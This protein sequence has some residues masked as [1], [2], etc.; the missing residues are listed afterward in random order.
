MFFISICACII[1]LLPQFVTEFLHKNYWIFVLLLIQQNIR[2][3][4]AYNC[5]MLLS[6]YWWMSDK[7]EA[8]CNIYLTLNLTTLLFTF[9]F[10]IKHS[11]KKYIQFVEFPHF[12]LFKQIIQWNLFFMSFPLF[13]Y[14]HSQSLY[15]NLTI[16]SFQHYI[17]LDFLRLYSFFSLVFFYFGLMYFIQ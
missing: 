11:A 15:Y 7:K 6:K 14:N 10:F 5:F 4:C 8:T 16:L 1:C 17:R 3:H 12:F 13:Q 9:P 2:Q